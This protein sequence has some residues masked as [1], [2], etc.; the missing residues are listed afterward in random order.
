MGLEAGV[1]NG[2]ATELC[3]G[4]DGRSAP[5]VSWLADGF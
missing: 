5:T 4:S 1:S 2:G 3:A